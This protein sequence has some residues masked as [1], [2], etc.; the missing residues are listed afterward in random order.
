MA[1]DNKSPVHAIQEKHGATFTEEDGGWF[2]SDNFG[3][4]NAEFAAIRKGASMWDVYALQKW[5]LTGPD[6][7]RAAQRLF[8]NNLATLV[9][10]Q[11]RYGA[12]VD[13]SGLMIDDGTIFKLS[14]DHWW[15]FTNSP[16]YAAELSKRTSDLTYDIVNRTSEMPV[17]SIQGPRSREI[18]QAL[19]DTNLHDI[20]YFRFLAEPVTLAGIPVR[21]LR[22]GFSGEL[23]FELIP[24]RE[25]AESL[26]LKLVESGV[27]PVGTDAVQIARAES[28]LIIMESDYFPGKTSPYDV[29]LD[30]MIALDGDLDFI[31][32]EALRKV[33]ANPPHRFKTLRI[34][35]A[36]VPADGAAVMKNGEHVGTVTS[37]V[38]SPDFGVLGL[39]VLRTEFS[40]DGEL[41]EVALPDGKTTATV[42]I[43]SIHDP[44]KRKPRS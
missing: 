8:T 32:K 44:D 12:M 21:V 34:D 18:L 2:W 43:L 9:S 7:A 24:R 33:A 28:G 26:W 3:D 27:T 31:G 13:E 1:T 20:R 40:G 42:T 6:A 15:V 11:V 38:M 4:T 17:L 30:K 22:T 39:A 23:G 41:V 10:G 36:T 5:D 37:P 19:T 35:G 14:D 29:S 16:E 25:D